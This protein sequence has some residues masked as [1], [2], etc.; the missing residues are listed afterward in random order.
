M[1]CS[2]VSFPTL[3]HQIGSCSN[4]PPCWM[5]QMHSHLIS[6][7]SVSLS[8]F[9]LIHRN[10]SHPCSG[11]MGYLTL[12]IL[13]IPLPTDPSASLCSRMQLPYVLHG[14]TMSTFPGLPK[15]W[16]TVSINYPRNHPEGLDHS[17]LNG[18]KIQSCKLALLKKR[19]WTTLY[20]EKRQNEGFPCNQCGSN[21]AEYGFSPALSGL[22]AQRCSAVPLCY[23]CLFCSKNPNHPSY[24]AKW[25]WHFC[26][27]VM[28]WN[29]TQLKPE[30][31]KLIKQPLS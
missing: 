30:S 26:D 25:P 3:L 15:K 1:A 19:F 27:T 23:L 31:L 28:R 4:K 11:T 10:Q 6:L 12:Q 14:P 2:Q 21:I 29:Q 17:W 5:H 18:D 7:Y 13:Q 8:G 24:R 9:L 20:R 22:R 16:I